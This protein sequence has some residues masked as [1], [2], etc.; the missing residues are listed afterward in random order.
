MPAHTLA[1]EP[2]NQLR[3]TVYAEDD[4]AKAETLTGVV[5]KTFSDHP[6]EQ[7]SALVDLSSASNSADPAT[8]KA[9]VPA[10]EHPQLTKVAFFG[11]LNETQRV[12]VEFAVRFAKSSKVG[13]FD[14]EQEAVNW[15]HQ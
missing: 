3:V 8:L 6:G 5:L 13:F 12:F 7:F 11:F 2:N 14:S 9:Y 1:I 15:L 10:L 4:A